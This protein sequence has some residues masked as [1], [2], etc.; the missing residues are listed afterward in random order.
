MKILLTLA[1]LAVTGIASALDLNNAQICG[2]LTAGRCTVY[3]DDVDQLVLYWN[4]DGHVTLTD[5][6][7]QTGEVIDVYATNLFRDPRLGL[8]NEVLTGTTGTV[9]LSGNLTS[10]RYLNR[11]GHNYYSWRTRFTDGTLER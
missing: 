5:Y 8:V 6:D 3:Q 10:Y 9:A 7:A 11:S 1:L 2:Q 4:V